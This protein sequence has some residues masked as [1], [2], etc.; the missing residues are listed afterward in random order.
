LDLIKCG[1]KEPAL[2][3]IRLCPNADTA[4]VFEVISHMTN[5]TVVAQTMGD[6]DL[7]VMAIYTDTDDFN[8]IFKSISNLKE[9]EYFDICITQKPCPPRTEEM[10]S[11]PY[12]GYY[13]KAYD[14]SVAPE[15]NKD[16]SY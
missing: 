13:S 15:K 10:F 1:F 11:F 5:V 3:L 8:A 9:I 16:N 4:K 7:L 14:P 2:L 12:Y 6:Y